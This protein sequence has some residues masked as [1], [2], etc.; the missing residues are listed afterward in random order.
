[1]R[2]LGHTSATL[3]GNLVGHYAVALP[4]ILMLAFSA[5]LGIIGVWWGLSAGLTVT[6]I[7]LVAMFLRGSKSG[8]K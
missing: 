8:Q 1:L 5:K 3:W 2:G 4:V 7:Y 6:A